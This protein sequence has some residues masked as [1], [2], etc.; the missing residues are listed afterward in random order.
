MQLTNE[1]LFGLAIEAELD[2]EC[3]L[4]WATLVDNGKAK[5]W[6]HMVGDKPSVS[7]ARF[8]FSVGFNRKNENHD[9]A[10]VNLWWEVHNFKIKENY[11]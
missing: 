1:Q 6:F 9:N 2:A 7:C 5:E 4:I 11:Q 10:V 8:L 3:M